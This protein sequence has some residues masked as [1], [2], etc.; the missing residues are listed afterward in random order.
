MAD[1]FVM[2]GTKISFDKTS[3]AIVLKGAVT[4]IAKS[5]SH[6]AIKDNAGLGRTFELEQALK[7]V[8]K[9]TDLKGF[10]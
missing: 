8:I 5:S 1:G 3:A 2:T 10:N 7:T 9:N 4:L 6:S